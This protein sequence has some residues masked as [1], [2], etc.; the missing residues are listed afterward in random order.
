MQ[1]ATTSHSATTTKFVKSPTAFPRPRSDTTHAR[2]RSLTFACPPEPSHSTRRS[3]MVSP[4]SSWSSTTRCSSPRPPTLTPWVLDV[5]HVHR[6]LGQTHHRAVLVLGCSTVQS[7]VP[8]L[9]TASLLIIASPALSLAAVSSIVPADGPAVRILRPHVQPSSAFG[10][11]HVLEWAARIARVWREDGG[12]VGVAELDEG[13]DG[14]KIDRKRGIFSRKTSSRSPEFGGGGGGERRLDAVLNFLDE[15]N[16]KDMETTDKTTLK[17]AILVGALSR[18]YVIGT[19]RPE[20]STFAR[21]SS[22]NLSPDSSRR[23]DLPKRD[24]PHSFISRPLSSLHLHSFKLSSI[25]KRRE[26]SPAPP[27]LEVPQRRVKSHEQAQAQTI[28]VLPPHAPSSLVAAL[29]SFLKVSESSSVTVSQSHPGSQSRPASMYDV[30]THSSSLR[31]FPSLPLLED[32]N[33]HT[34]EQHGAY[35]VPRA[36]L[37]APVSIPAPTADA[38]IPAVTVGELLLRGLGPRDAILL[39]GDVVLNGADT[40][41][42][43]FGSTSSLSAAPRQRAR[44]RHGRL[45]LSASFSNSFVG[46]DTPEEAE[47]VIP[48]L[49]LIPPTPKHAVPPSRFPS[50]STIVPRSPL[51]PAAESDSSSPSTARSSPSLTPPADLST[52]DSSRTP[53]VAEKTPGFADWMKLPGRTA[54]V[55]EEARGWRFWRAS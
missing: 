4:S 32:E 10:L 55:S 46:E 38:S 45:S 44:M 13:D 53:S 37:S 15:G 26:K 9:S 42:S 18:P 33:E 16:G 34:S 54:V 40:T 1:P 14:E 7:L 5:E 30:P 48:V 21:H 11:I 19:S 41:L 35:I 3:S 22:T 47:D 28:H 52:P 12:V 24:R 20:V 50:P 23:P 2:P 29:A 39:G 36:M 17:H 6:T 31:N 49:T 51:A 8:L 27:T 25:G 43:S